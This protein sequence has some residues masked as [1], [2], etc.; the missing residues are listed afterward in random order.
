[1]SKTVYVL[2]A[3]FS[4]CS[5]APLQK[6]IL[7]S[8]FE[9][10]VPYPN[11]YNKSFVDARKRLKNFLKKI[12]NENDINKLARLDLENLFTILDKAI[13]NRE[14]IRNNSF[15]KITKLRNDLNCCIVY[16]FNEKLI[17]DIGGFYYKL[18]RAIVNRRT[19]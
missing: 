13:L 12:F 14:F 17:R 16:M 2:G 10:P 3:G 4:K 9:L 1:M 5:E 19:S 6:D 15:E 7:R 11:D 8:I 18:A